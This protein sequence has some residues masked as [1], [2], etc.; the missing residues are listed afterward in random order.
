MALEDRIRSSIETALGGLATRVNEDVRTVVQ[1][2]ISVAV[3]DRDEALDAARRAAR[4]QAST[5][6]QRHVEEAEAGA[7][8][9]LL[10]SVRALDRAGSLTDVLDALAHAASSEAS[11]V[12]VF[13]VRN[14]RL[15]GWRFTGFGEADAEP[16]TIQLGLDNSGV[17][18]M[19]VSS[20]RPV[21]TR[22]GRSGGDGPGFVSVPPGALGAAVPVMVGGRVVA[23]VYADSVTTDGRAPLSGAWPQVIEL[24]A[25]HAARCLEALT[26]QKTANPQSPRFWAAGAARSNQS[27]EGSAVRSLAETQS[28]SSALPGVMT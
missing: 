18:G 11:R 5:E 15:L 10:E 20:G 14:E 21:T 1:Q 16:K 24:L 17:V 12:A 28:P 4:E 9:R 25:R 2:L 19:A 26:V 7:L 22:E 23:A 8:T 6:M 3:A 13:V 27:P